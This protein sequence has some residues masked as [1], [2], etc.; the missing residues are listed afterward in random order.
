M[1]T[2]TNELYQKMYH[3]ITSDTNNFVKDEIEGR[4]KVLTEKYAYIQ[5]TFYA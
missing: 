5:S 1:K 4:E 2:S 3:G